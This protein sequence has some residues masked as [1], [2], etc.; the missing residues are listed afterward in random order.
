MSPQIG[1]AAADPRARG[2]VVVVADPHHGEAV[3]GE[4]RK[5]GVALLVRSAGFSRRSDLRREEFVQALTGASAHDFLHCSRKKVDRFWS[6]HL[7]D[8]E[9]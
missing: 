5:P 8:R 7:L 6:E 4:T 3:A 1:S 9:G 2:A